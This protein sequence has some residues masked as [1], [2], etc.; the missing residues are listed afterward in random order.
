M[1]HPT[2]G[3]PYDPYR[4]R[5]MAPPPAAGLP[6]GARSLATLFAVL[7]GLGFVAAVG[8]WTSAFMPAFTGAHRPDEGLF[9]V[10]SIVLL[11][12]IFVFYAQCFA[13]MYWVYKAWAWLP[14]EQRY[15]R[16][17]RSWITPAQAALFLLI[18]Y[19]QYYWM[20]VIN[21]GLC[22]AFDRM[23]VMYP[24]REAPSKG[25]AIA[26]SVCQVA[27]PMP[28]GSILWIVFMSNM[29][30]V[31]HEMSATGSRMPYAG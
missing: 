23:R 10:G 28:V 12:T 16:H 21:C 27:V 5:A 22:D 15:T 3:I 2:E 14:P 11:V 8:I 31:T 9:M 18:P 30:R 29:D 7:G 4:G 13:G 20:F 19:F 6:R 26:A 1:T 25:L 24:T 17:W